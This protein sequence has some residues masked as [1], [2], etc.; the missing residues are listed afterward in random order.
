MAA[1]FLVAALVFYAAT[2]GFGDNPGSASLARLGEMLS[3]R[4]EQD[5]QRAPRVLA[6]LREQGWSVRPQGGSADNGSKDSANSG[7]RPKRAK[8]AP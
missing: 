2:V 8:Q 3:D 7:A 6:P 1:W 5:M 4:W